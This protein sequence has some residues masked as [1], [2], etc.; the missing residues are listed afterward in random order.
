MIERLAVTL[1][2]MAGRAPEA[3]AG[4][5]AARLLADCADA[6]R[7]E[8]DCPQQALTSEQRSS[9]KQLGDLLEDADLVPHR[10]SAAAARTCA[11][12]GLVPGHSGRLRP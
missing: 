3:L 4:A 5:D 1:R 7:L 11:A 10:V 12:L 9:L 2:A 6:V 8:L